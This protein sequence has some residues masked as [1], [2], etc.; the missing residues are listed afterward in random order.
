MIPSFCSL[1][2]HHMNPS[3]WLKPFQSLLVCCDDIIPVANQPHLNGI[4]PE[5]S[6]E[7]SIKVLSFPTSTENRLP[8][9]SCVIGYTGHWRSPAFVDG[10]RPNTCGVA[11]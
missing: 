8:S 3:P 7:Y 11:S 10:L 6:A 1:S 4:S 5:Y 2:S 9:A